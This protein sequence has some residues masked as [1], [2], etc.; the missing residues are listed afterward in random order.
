MFQCNALTAVFVE[1]FNSVSEDVRCYDT[2]TCNPEW[3]Q[4]CIVFNLV[5]TSLGCRYKR[6]Y[7]VVVP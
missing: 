1:S 6:R 4:I 3:Q 7:S 5:L 2:I